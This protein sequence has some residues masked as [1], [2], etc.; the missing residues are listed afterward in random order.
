MGRQRSGCGAAVERPHWSGVEGRSLVEPG[1][2]YPRCLGFV[3]GD[4]VEPAAC[5]GAGRGA[6]NERW[7]RRT[8]EHG[9]FPLG[10]LPQARRS[11]RKVLLARLDGGAAGAQ[12]AFSQPD[13][14]PAIAQVTAA[15][16]AA[17][18]VLYA[19]VRASAPGYVY[20][21]DPGRSVLPG[22]RTTAIDAQSLSRPMARGIA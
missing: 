12:E 19:S 22:W 13:R 17:T 1:L 15:G 4:P 20:A 5:M 18:S 10:R 11:S 16:A 8:A 14:N 9:G 7:F 3:E 2:A 6:P 21:F